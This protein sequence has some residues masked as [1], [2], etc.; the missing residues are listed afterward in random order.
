ME[1]HSK[2]DTNENQD[3]DKKEFRFLNET[4]KNPDGKKQLRRRI[5]FL[6]IAM[7]AGAVGAF[8]FTLLKPAAQRLISGDGKERVN[9]ATVADSSAVS[10]SSVLSDSTA[11]SISP[12]E[13]K[14]GD[15]E[16][17]AAG[18][19]GET[20]SEGAAGAEGSGTEEETDLDKYR[21]VRREINNIVVNCEKSVVSVTGIRSEMD[22]FN[23][24]YENSSSAY[25]VII[26]DHDSEYYIL[27]EANATTDAEQ[28]RVVFFNGVELDAENIRSDAA[29]GFAVIRVQKTGDLSASSLP[30]AVTLGNSFG[31]ARGDTVVALG[32]PSGYGSSYSIGA[33][34]SNTNIVSLTDRNYHILTTDIKGSEGGSGVLMNLDGKI[35]GIID[36]SLGSDDSSIVKAI[37][38]SELEDLMQKLSN[39]ETRPYVGISGENVTDVIS[40]KTGIPR[41]VMVSGVAQDS[42]AMLAGI[43]QQDIITKLNGKDI[44]TVNEYTT[45]IEACTP[46]S[47]LHVTA[48]RKGAAGY[49]EVTFDVTVGEC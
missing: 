30:A 17:N 20:G 44:T 48:Q 26:A 19:E 37:G 9:I 3:T 40:R 4:I 2:S 14:S 27:T 29:T 23:N 39:N 6:L 28:I 21:L 12:A 31:L 18:S 22:Y 8:L 38:V 1:E 33:I 41:G 10:V 32:D 15:G 35:V 34:T 7:A 43:K 5:L 36:Q 45:F 16:K 11:A 49:E 13:Q 24:T 46:G 47:T 25:G 42:P